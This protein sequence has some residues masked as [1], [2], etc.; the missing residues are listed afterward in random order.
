MSNNELE[1][2][3]DPSNAPERWLS[4]TRVG[5]RTFQSAMGKGPTAKWDWHDMVSVELRQSLTKKETKRQSIIFELI[6]GEMAYVKDLE[7]INVVR[8]ISVPDF[9]ATT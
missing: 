8:A 6:K 4:R 5:T 7:N 9:S 1:R 3:R 2:P